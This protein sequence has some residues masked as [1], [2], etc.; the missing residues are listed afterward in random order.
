[1]LT[2]NLA[3]VARSVSVPVE[4]AREA[5]R[6]GFWVVGVRKTG[7]SSQRRRRGS[8]RGAVRGEFV[9]GDN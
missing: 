8:A 5:G 4:T 7:T 2:Q 3:K 9:V 1:M 6:G